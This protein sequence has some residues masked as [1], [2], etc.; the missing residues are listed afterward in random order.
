MWGRRRVIKSIKSVALEKFLGGVVENKLICGGD[1]GLCS[2]VRLAVMA[3]RLALLRKASRGTSG[4]WSSSV[5]FGLWYANLS[6]SRE[7]R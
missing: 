3:V 7:L 2:Y 4:R 5:C 1:D 6:S